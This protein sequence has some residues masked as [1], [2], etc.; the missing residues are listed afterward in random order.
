MIRMASQFP[1]F[2]NGLATAALLG[3]FALALPVAGQETAADPFSSVSAQHE[4]SLWKNKAGR[5]SVV[6]EGLRF[7]VSSRKSKEAPGAIQLAWTDI[8]Q[9]ILEEDTVS[10]VTYQD[11]RWQLGRDRHYRFHLSE[12]GLAGNE[13]ESLL[14]ERLGN[15]LVLATRGTQDL[16]LWQRSAKL[17]GVFSGTEGVLIF[18]QNELQF[19]TEKTG[20]GRRWPLSQIG[21]VSRVNATELL[22]TAPE[23]AVSDEGRQRSFYFQLKQPLTQKQFQELWRETEEA[24]GLRLRLID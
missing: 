16:V 7:E 10:V 12:S 11:Q 3:A 8:Q 22:V 6:P 2:F 1:Q 5:L 18:S 13:L 15:R 23:R 20:K 19:V 9:L 4:R 21:T 24:Q 17:S 14:R